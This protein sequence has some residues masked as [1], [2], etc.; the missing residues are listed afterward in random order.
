MKIIKIAQTNMIISFDFDDTL[1]QGEYDTTEGDF[2][3]DSEGDAIGTLREDIARMVHHY[4]SKGIKIIIVSSRYDKHKNE[5]IEFV[6][7]HNLPISEFHCTNGQDKVHLLKSL[8]VSKHFD[9]DKFEI[10]K[11]NRDGQL[12]GILV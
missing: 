3:R 5:M 7:K 9:D 1:F 8:G 11:I 6:Q 10:D 2:K 4:A 12:M